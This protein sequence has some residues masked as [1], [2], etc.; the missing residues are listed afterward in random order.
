MQQRLQEKEADF[1]VQFDQLLDQLKGKE[2][3]LQN[4]V[5][6]KEGLVMRLKILEDKKINEQL[7]EQKLQ[8]R[9]NLLMHKLRR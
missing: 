9:N 8:Q 1:K 2:Q 6:E 5:K 3:S 4:E 7:N